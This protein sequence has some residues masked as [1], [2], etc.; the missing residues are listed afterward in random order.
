VPTP[1]SHCVILVNV[2]TQKTLALASCRA[3][4]GLLYRIEGDLKTGGA[5]GPLPPPPLFIRYLWRS[6]QSHA[7]QS[8]HI[9]LIR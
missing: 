8:A 5:T 2:A 9:V 6:A 3:L 7:R 4:P 1:S